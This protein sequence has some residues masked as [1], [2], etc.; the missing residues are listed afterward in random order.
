MIIQVED[1]IVNGG[2]TI[3]P[4]TQQDNEVVTLKFVGLPDIAAGQVV[5]LTWVSRDET[6]GAEEALT[7]EDGGY[8][9]VIGSDISAHAA[10]DAF[11][12]VTAGERVWNSKS[13]RIQL[14]LLPD[15]EG[16]IHSTLPETEVIQ[17]VLS[18]LSLAG[19]R[20]DTAAD[21]ANA[22]ALSAESAAQAAMS[23][24]EELESAAQDASGAASQAVA[25]AGSVT[26]A[27]AA[28]VSA[29]SAANSAAQAALAQAET[30]R[31]ETEAAVSRTD[32]AISEISEAAAQAIGQAA[33]Q[34][35]AALTQSASRADSAAEAA[36]AAA[37]SALSAADSWVRTDQAQNLTDAQKATARLNVDAAA[38]SD[39]DRLFS[40]MDALTQ[41]ANEYGGVDALVFSDSAS[42]DN[43]GV[44]FAF[45]ETGACQVSGTASGLAIHNFFYGLTSLPAWLV[46]GHSYDVEYQSRGVNLQIWFYKNGVYF[47]GNGYKSGGRFT[48]PLDAEGCIVRLSVPDGTSVNE[49]VH[50]RVWSAQT[51]SAL[52]AQVESLT[53][54]QI[55]Y[56][57]V[58]PNANHLDDVGETGVYLLTGNESAPTPYG[59]LFHLEA[60]DATRI[61]ILFALSGLKIYYRRYTGA[62]QNWN[63]L[64]RLY[65]PNPYFRDKT[66]LAFGD[67]LS[68]GAL[69]NTG[70]DGAAVITRASVGSRIPDRIANAVNCAHYENLSV[71]GM[72]FCKAGTST[73]TFLN[74][75]KSQDIRSADLITLMGGRNDGDYPLGT[76]ESEPGENTIC[77]QIAAI[78]EYIR[79]VNSACQ[80]V[81]IQV[82]PYTGENQPFSRVYHNGEWSLDSFDEQVSQLCKKYCAGYCSWYGCSLFATWTQQ[83][84]GGGN[85]AHMREDSQYEQMGDFIAGQVARWYLN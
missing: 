52:Q 2:Q 61:Q 75:I 36:E 63:H 66:Y 44:T 34:A 38:Q 46:K 48:V 76:S 17:Q 80:I 51:N 21:A 18:L 42:H 37:S 69:W 41:A 57:G 50:P 11:L 24:T 30:C 29:T 53:S 4:G 1:R 16:A 14:N 27:V 79:S 55:P 9:F 19:A 32:S 3:F 15:I 73:P 45:D 85:Y 78:I 62:W 33:S 83:S 40:A 54:G 7:P 6:A 31:S 64:D 82:T 67:S 72:A 84:G 35:E 28:S 12:R 49:T 22:A 20:A 77:G 59:T 8:A 58:Y 56:R 43:R 10:V 26:D 70:L 71:G 13:F 25:A 68:Y 47:S 74:Y 5:T 60:S 39:A 81:V 65:K 23:A